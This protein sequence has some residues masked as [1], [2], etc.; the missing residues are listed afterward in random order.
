[1]AD[2]DQSIYNIR[3]NQITMGMEGFGG[4]TPQWTPLILTAD[5]NGPA[6]ATTEIQFNNAGAFGA[7]A[8]LRFSSDSIQ[9]GPV[10][11]AT[12]VYSSSGLGSDH[13]TIFV[14]SGYI[15]LNVGTAAGQGVIISED[16]S[17]APNVSATLQIDS[18]TKGLLLPRMSTT[19]RDAIATPAEGL[20]V[21]NLTTHK[22]NFY[23][24]SAWVVVT[25]S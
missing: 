9:V 3:Y 15:S 11:Q 20:M 22:L 24:G 4:G 12:W 16:E 13:G 7:S 5:G 21:Y 1:M 18:T 8:H 2:L 25:S 14:D 19:Q 6:G 23:N 10:D 17:T